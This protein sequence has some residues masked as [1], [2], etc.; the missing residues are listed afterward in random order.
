MHELSLCHA[1]ADTARRHAD[2]REVRSVTVRIGHL[3]QVVVESLVF[4]WEVLV[5]GTDLAGAT[6]EV[7]QVPAVIVCRPCG[8][9]TSLDQVSLLC[10]E[11]DSA[12]VEVVSG[13]EFQIA[14]LDVVEEAS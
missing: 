8:A 3:R 9:T 4:S 2:H 10:P 5:D 1:I 13:E 12:D 6:L 7:E 11:C 14:A